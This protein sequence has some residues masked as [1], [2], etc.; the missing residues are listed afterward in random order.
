MISIRNMHHTHHHVAK[1]MP[2]PI[3][4][5]YANAESIFTFSASAPWKNEWL[6]W[7]RFL[8]SSFRLLCPRHFGVHWDWSI[9]QLGG[10]QWLVSKAMEH[11]NAC[12]VSIA[13][14][15]QVLSALWHIPLHSDTLACMWTQ[16]ARRRCLKSTSNLC[17][18]V[19]VNS[20]TLLELILFR[21]NYHGCAEQACCSPPLLSPRSCHFRPPITNLL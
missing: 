11:A 10:L 4:N 8:Y 7:H 1:E 18:H 16:R 13:Q 5:P 12:S 9:H 20:Q 2:L 19:L 15:C 21:I 14:W 17:N 6:P 3:S